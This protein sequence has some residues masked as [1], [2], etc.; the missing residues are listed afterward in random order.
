[1]IADYYDLFLS[2]VK[3]ADVAPEIYITYCLDVYQDN[4][5]PGVKLDVAPCNN[6][7]AQN[8]LPEAI[9]AQILHYYPSG[10]YGAGS[11]YYFPLDVHGGDTSST[12]DGTHLDIAGYN[13]SAAQFFSMQFNGGA[14]NWAQ[15]LPF[16][17]TY[18]SPAQCI[19]YGNPATTYDLVLGACSGTTSWYYSLTQQFVSGAYPNNCMDD[20]GDAVPGTPSLSNPVGLAGC[21]NDN[22]AQTWDVFLPGQLSYM[23]YLGISSE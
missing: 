16:Y 6:T 21:T 5:A 14:N 19:E 10:W 13:G 22:L 20:Y 9:T 18:E 12:P 15:I 4:Q 1:L 11:V 17:G 3:K 23:S 7:N 2:Q 8:F